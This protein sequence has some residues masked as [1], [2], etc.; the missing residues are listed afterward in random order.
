[1]SKAESE[2]NEIRQNHVGNTGKRVLLLEGPDDVAAF[3]QLLSRRQFDGWEINWAIAAAGNKN[4]ALEIAPLAPNW[5]VLVDRDEWSD[6]DL[7]K[8]QQKHP[9]LLV[10]PRFCLE[11]YLSDPDELW[12]ELPDGQKN[13]ITGGQAAFRAEILRDLAKWQR[14]AAI[15]QVI[16]PL[17]AGL[18]ALGFKEKLLETNSVAD[19]A[20][21]QTTLQNWSDFIDATRIMNDVQTAIANMQQVAPSVFLHHH[22]YAK[23]FFPEVVVP[24][25]NRLFRQQPEAKHRAELFS[26]IPVPTDLAFVW[27]RMGLSKP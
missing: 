12:Q 19:D 2:I 16:N 9:N 10:L 13:K 17:W 14:H 4:R 7:K 8:H 23:N 24:A 11:S 18:R 5:L 22:L 26:A 15:W 20:E 21:L 3:E 25:L 1:M 6:A 27:Q